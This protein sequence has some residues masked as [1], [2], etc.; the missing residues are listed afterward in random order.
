MCID[1]ERERER[2]RERG[3]LLRTV[4]YYFLLNECIT[5]EFGVHAEIDDQLEIA[6]GGPKT[7]QRQNCIHAC[8]ERF[9][10]LDI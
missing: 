9:I 7:S 6:L 10:N 5:S 8:L 2:E 1:K 4:I 3:V